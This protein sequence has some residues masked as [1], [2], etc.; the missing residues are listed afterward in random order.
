MPCLRSPS[1]LGLTPGLLRAAWSWPPRAAVAPEG[2]GGC[3]E[4]GGRSEGLVA[5]R[6]WAL[7]ADSSPEVSF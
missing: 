3:S 5:S 4:R 1:A 2:H 7:E 6:S